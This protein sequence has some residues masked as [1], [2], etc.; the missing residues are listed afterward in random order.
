MS[1]RRHSPSDQEVDLEAT[2]ELPL[3]DFSAPAEDETQVLTDNF[4]VP[5]FPAGV[6]ELAD[7]LRDVESRLQR[8]GERV[9]QL[10][11]QL[12][13][14]E[15]RERDLKAEQDRE[16]AA[17]RQRDT[18]SARQNTDNG[19]ALETLRADLAARESALLSTQQALE[20][21]RQ[22]LA[23]AKAEH[24]RERTVAQQR[25]IDTARQI[26]ETGQTLT[27]VRADLAARE[28]TLLSTQQALESERQLLTAARRE[29]ETRTTAFQHQA[30]DLAAARSRSERQI[31]ALQN[32]QALLGVREAMIGE[33]DAELM[34]I[35]AR[36]SAA[37]AELE[38]K[39]KA[40]QAEL[41]EQTAAL[42]AELHDKTAALQ[43]ELKDRT[44]A[45]QDEMATRLA[46]K[47][48]ELDDAESRVRTTV[49]DLGAHRIL[50]ESAVQKSM[51]LADQVEAGRARLA[52]QEAELAALQRTAEQARLGASVYAEQKDKT[53]AAVGLESA[54]R[55]GPLEQ[56][57]GGRGA[58]P[59][60]ESSMPGCDA[61]NCRKTSRGSAAKTQLAATLQARARPESV[62]VE[63]R[64]F[65]W[66][67]KAVRDHTPYRAPRSRARGHGIQIDPVQAAPLW[68]SRERSIAWSGMNSTNGVCL[69]AA[70]QT[71]YPHDGISHIGKRVPLTS[72]RMTATMSS[73]SSSAGYDV[74]IETALD[75]SRVF[76][77]P[78]QRGVQERGTA[79]R[80]SFKRGGL[81]K[82]ANI[83]ETAA[84]SGVSGL[85]GNN[86]QGVALA[87]T[88]RQSPPIG[89]VTTPAT[90]STR[91]HVSCRGGAAWRCL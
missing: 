41:K 35:E 57:S 47:Q 84:R 5:V 16:R 81:T 85:A 17:A 91:W 51:E 49:A 43:T 69:M 63:C 34:G 60:L 44:T 88:A 65:T 30:T 53:G 36:H 77:A 28:T 62:G 29:V 9:K 13:A 64:P 1:V 10:E 79:A 23:A 80:F 50:L 20:S 6:S 11:S 33:R 71:S 46:A 59:R 40:L 18:D 52:T 15:T 4:A 31:E 55:G 83:S 14:A 61:G 67:G 89:A 75:P 21:E 73:E 37:I 38:A 54:R 86:A 82:I 2:A 76:G 58:N 26:A 24:D 48:V 27:N 42:Q 68:C 70:A 74:A 45:L 87:R 56:I 12:A 39:N 7:S 25:E 3:I 32:T 22:L 66:A 78:G 19:R 8:K 90:R 72:A